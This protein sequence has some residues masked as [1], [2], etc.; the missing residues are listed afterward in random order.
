MDAVQRMRK[1][2]KDAGN[3]KSS[4][5]QKVETK[6]VES[7][8]VIVVE[9]ANPQVVYVPSYNPTVVYG[10]PVYAYPPSPIRRRDTTRP[11]WPFRL[12]LVWQWEPRWGGGWGYNSGWGG[13]NN[14]TINNNNNFVNNSNGK[15]STAATATTAPVVTAI[16]STIR[17]T[18]AERLMAIEAPQTSTVATLAETPC[19]RARTTPARTRRGTAAGCRKSRH[20]EPWLPG[21]APATRDARKPRRRECR[22]YEQTAAP[23]ADRVGNRQVRNTP[24]STNR[25]AFGGAG[26]GTSGS[27]HA[28]VVHAAPPAWAALAAGGGSRGGGG[29]GAGRKDI[30]MKSEELM[31]IENVDYKKSLA[32]VILVGLC[33]A[34]LMTSWRKPSPRRSPQRSPRRLRYP[35]A[36]SRCADHSGG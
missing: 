15:T 10:P 33:C 36:G 20:L 7:K 12:A 34:L 6:V 24:S 26:G 16:G 9:Q 18:V 17:S 21:P 30:M 35:P 19:S 8:Q 2:A 1:K 27:W 28:P 13:N 22:Q 25:S 29:G 3:L 4:E 32:T 31:N 5:Q 14:V 11:G 23:R